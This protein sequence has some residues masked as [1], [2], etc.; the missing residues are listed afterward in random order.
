MRPRRRVLAFDFDQSL[1]FAEMFHRARRAARSRAFTKPSRDRDRRRNG[2]ASRRARLGRDR[3]SQGGVRPSAP[4]AGLDCG[5][6]ICSKLGQ[7]GVNM[8]LMSAILVAASLM[9][10]S[11]ARAGSHSVSMGVGLTIVADCRVTN[12]AAGSRLTVRPRSP[13]TL[14]GG[15]SPVHVTTRSATAASPETVTMTY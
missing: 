1:Q 10:T 11:D 6:P 4:L 2:P 5:A 15:N 8:R 3:K 7:R 14:R 12:C 9:A 13:S